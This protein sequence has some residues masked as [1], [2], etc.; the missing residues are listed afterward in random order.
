MSDEREK[1]ILAGDVKL[2][3]N[4]EK[5]YLVRDDKGFQYICTNARDARATMATHV[6]CYGCGAI[7]KKT[8]GMLCPRC[9]K[10]NALENAGEFC[11]TFPV[12]VGGVFCSTEAE[13]LEQVLNKELELAELVFYTAWPNYPGNVTQ[14]DIEELFTDFLFEDD[15]LPSPVQEACK[16]FHEALKK[17]KDPISWRED[18]PVRLSDCQIMDYSEKLAKLK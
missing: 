12:F 6:K 2:V 14:D 9:E 13:F 4:P 16:D 8:E 10:E 11:G 3:E 18:D 15:S 5:T 17:I 7:V 1:I